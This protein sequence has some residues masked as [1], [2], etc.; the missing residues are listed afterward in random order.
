MCQVNTA[1][2]DGV[3]LLSDWYFSE[4]FGAKIID[5]VFTSSGGVNAS[6]TAELNYTASRYAFLAKDYMLNAR[7]PSTDEWRRELLVGHSSTIKP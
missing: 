7:I 1:R 2:N 3:V 5:Y 6:T 4:A